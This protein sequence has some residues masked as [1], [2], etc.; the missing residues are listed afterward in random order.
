MV[1]V[2]EREGRMRVRY[3]HRGAAPAAPA[4]L[5]RASAGAESYQRVPRL[6]CPALA[7]PLAVVFPAV[8]ADVNL[9]GAL[10]G[11]FAC[12]RRECGSRPAALS[13]SSAASAAGLGGGGQDPPDH[14]GEADPLADS[15]VQPARLKRTRAETAAGWGGTGAGCRRVGRRR[16]LLTREDHDAA[17]RATG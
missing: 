10:P 2:A 17:L 11:G 6:A 12:R 15:V 5:A 1:L 9:L 3:L 16:A 4:R 8:A 14:P 7:L 13:D